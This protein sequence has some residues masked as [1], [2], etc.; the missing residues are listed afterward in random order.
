MHAVKI[1]IVIPEDHQLQ[2]QLPAYLP[3]GPAEIIVLSPRQTAEE[4][5]APRRRRSPIGWLADEPELADAL[6]KSVTEARAADRMR[7]F[8]DDEDAP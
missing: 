1:A 2:I 3:S 7:T 5:A 6:L 4:P 8:D